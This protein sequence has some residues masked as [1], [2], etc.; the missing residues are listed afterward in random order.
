[1]P[2]LTVTSVVA[3]AAATP[4]PAAPANITPPK[5]DAVL[6]AGRPL[7]VKSA[8]EGRKEIALMPLKIDLG[9]AALGLDPLALLPPLP[10]VVQR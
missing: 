9:L 7:G 4:R 6:Q 10:P 1:M 8:E 5:E 3:P 2:A